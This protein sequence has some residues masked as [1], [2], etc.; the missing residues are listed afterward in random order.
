VQIGKVFLGGDSAGG[1]LAL[2]LTHHLITAGLRLPDALVMNYPVVDVNP[3][4]VG[5]TWIHQF[6]DPIMKYT[7]MIHAVEAYIGDQ[8]T[9]EDAETNALLSP[10]RATSEVTSFKF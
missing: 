6:E 4:R 3:R 1:H 5:K 7:F 10:I 9:Q 2:T 8:A